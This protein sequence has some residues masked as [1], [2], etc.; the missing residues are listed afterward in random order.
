MSSATVWRSSYKPRFDQ[1]LEQ[2]VMTQPHSFPCRDPRASRLTRPELCLR[3]LASPERWPCAIKRLRLGPS[4]LR[5]SSA[6]LIKS[7]MTATKGEQTQSDRNTSQTSVH[8]WV[9]DLNLN[10]AD[11]GKLS[12][13]PRPPQAR[14]R[15]PGSI[16]DAVNQVIHVYVHF[17]VLCLCVLEKHRSF[18]GHR[19]DILGPVQ[20]S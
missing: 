16:K 8:Q 1:V 11:T 19:F 2:L 10:G 3:R 6:P 4:Q 17:I 15:G 14:Q 7:K 13:Y 18:A 9:A 5:A 20:R 12:N